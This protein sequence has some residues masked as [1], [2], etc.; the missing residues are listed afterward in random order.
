MDEIPKEKAI[1]LTTKKS[2]NNI[3]ML[4]ATTNNYLWQIFFLK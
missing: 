2:N 1:D 3:K 4:K